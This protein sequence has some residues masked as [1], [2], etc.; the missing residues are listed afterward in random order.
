M[1]RSAVSA[2]SSV[3]LRL[4]QQ[5]GGLAQLDAAVGARGDAEGRASVAATRINGVAARPAKVGAGR[6]RLPSVRCLRAANDDGTV[7]SA[8][9]GRD[10]YQVIV[11]SVAEP[12]NRVDRVL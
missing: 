10:S 8:G 6:S 12:G 3:L 11:N 4:Q 2:R 5:P 1:T 7:V 9:R